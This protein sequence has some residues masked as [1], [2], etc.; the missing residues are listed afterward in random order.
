MLLSQTR[1]FFSTTANASVEDVPEAM[2]VTDEAA[3]QNQSFMDW[4]EEDKPHNKI[5]YRVEKR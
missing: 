3:E 1:V 4:V 2:I 5:A